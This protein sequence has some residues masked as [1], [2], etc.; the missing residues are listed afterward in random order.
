MSRPDRID[1]EALRGRAEYALRFDVDHA[2][3]LYLRLLASVYLAAEGDEQG[4]EVL[5]LEN[6]YQ[7]QAALEE[8]DGDAILTTLLLAVPTSEVPS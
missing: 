8:I 4:E 5:A 3:S 1:T 7:V 2:G 6:I